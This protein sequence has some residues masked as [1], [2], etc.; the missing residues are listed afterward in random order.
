MRLRILSDIHTEF[1]KN[2][3]EDFVDNVP[4]GPDEILI[5]AGDIG[6]IRDAEEVE[7]LTQVLKAFRSKFEDV[8]YVPGN[9]DHW[10]HTLSEGE[11]ILREV[12]E[13][14][15]VKL[16]AS[17]DGRYALPNNRWLFGGTMWYPE[18]HATMTQG[19]SD[20]A[21]IPNGRNDIF[22]AHYDFRHHFQQM[23][24]PGD[25]VVTH[26][27]PSSRSVHPRYRT[28]NLND[29]FLAPMDTF[30][31]DHKPALWVHGHMH[32]PVDYVC[33][34]SGTRVVSNPVGYPNEPGL[35]EPRLDFTVEIK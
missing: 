15:G 2:P 32:N 1:Y 11:R 25:I 22:D 23:V 19:W 4:A 3:V 24:Q 18:T 13:T 26:M 16:V 33:R 14:A 27:A 20:F 9:H 35:D 21:L 10:Y 29:F 12:S 7:R 5:L 31:Y 6:T 28:S 8:F 30:I 34:G 17:S